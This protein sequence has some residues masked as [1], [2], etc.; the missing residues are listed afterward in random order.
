MRERNRE[1]R[2]DAVLV[3]VLVVLITL[4]LLI[5]TVTVVKAFTQSVF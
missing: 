5:T 1:V 3:A 4:F 2:K